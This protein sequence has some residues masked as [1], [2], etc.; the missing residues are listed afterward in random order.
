MRRKL[1]QRTRTRRSPPHYY[2]SD[3]DMPVEEA[4]KALLM[5]YEEEENPQNRMLKSEN[6]F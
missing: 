5:G 2:D 3:P 1:W 6:P 4:E